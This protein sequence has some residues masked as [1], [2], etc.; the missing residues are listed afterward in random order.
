MLDTILKVFFVK[1]K[2]N[3]RKNNGVHICLDLNGRFPKGKTKNPEDIT[4]LSGYFKH[5]KGLREQVNENHFLR[6]RQ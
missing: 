1:Y 2:L 3:S 6:N 5:I 4:V